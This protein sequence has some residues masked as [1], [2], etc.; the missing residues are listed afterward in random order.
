MISRVCERVPEM[1]SPS[2]LFAFSKVAEAT[3]IYCC[4]D[5][6]IV[7]FEISLRNM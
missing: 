5:A 4:A 3:R 2:Q 1:E 6:D 7:N